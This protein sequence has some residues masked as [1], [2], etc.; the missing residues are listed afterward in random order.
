[1]PLRPIRRGGVHPADS[2]HL[3]RRQPVAVRGARV[4]AEAGRSVRADLARGR[5]G[6]EQSFPHYGLRDRASRH[7][8]SAGDGGLTADKISVGAP[9]FNLTFAP[10]FPPLLIAVP[11]G[12]ML[13]WK[14]GDL[15]G[16]A[17]RLLAAGVAGLVADRDRL[18]LGARRQRAGAVG[19]RTS[20]LRHRR[21]RSDLVERTGLFRLP[22]ATRC[23]APAVCRAR[24]GALSLRMP[25]SASP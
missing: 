12:P 2:L 23:V 6:A 15:L 10:L 8:L 14:R 25:A 18:G 11:F 21:R 17:Q 5:A 9:F 3:H 7:A 1:M 13:A 4:V 22:F 20:R 16:A 19:D 24:P